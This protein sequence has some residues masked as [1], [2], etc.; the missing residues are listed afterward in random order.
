MMSKTTTTIFAM[1]VAVIVVSS[2]TSAAYAHMFSVWSNP[3]Q[4][5]YCTTSLDTIPHTSK[6][7]TCGDLKTSTDRWNNISSSSLS[8]TKSATYYA[9]VISI[10]GTNLGS[11]VTGYMEPY[12]GA[13]N[14]LVS[15]TVAYNTHTSI[16]YGDVAL[17]DSASN[18]I[19]YQSVAGHE[20]A[21]AMGVDHNSSSLS[22]MYP[23]ISYN[24]V[25]RNTDAHDRITVIGAYP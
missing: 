2:G 3:T 5:Y 11:G 17:G 23:S 12:S 24:Q 25:N 8:L 20:M 15:A 18:M 7:L 1:L 14:P 13:P 16:K 9:G 10:F 19:D 22:V 21:H 4:K 6:V